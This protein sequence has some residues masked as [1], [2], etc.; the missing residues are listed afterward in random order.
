[1]TFFP[2][3]GFRVR[4]VRLSQNMTQKVFAAS[5]GIVQ[6]FLSAVENGKKMP[7]DTFLLALCGKYQIDQDWLL[8]GQGEMRGAVLGGAPAPVS[9]G[10]PLLRRITADFPAVA[11]ADIKDYVRLPGVPAGCYAVQFEGDFMAPTI[12]DGDL[13]VFQ[14]GVRAE[15][16]DIL[17]VTNHWGEVILRRYRL[18]GEQ[19]YLSADNS[20]YSPFRPDPE[21]RIVGK[22]V[23][24]WRKVKM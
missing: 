14:S 1:M 18:Q 12:S 5:L 11:D 3:V 6:G 15:N 22:V 13:V 21:T 8:T 20:S 9:G 7:S 19:I 24:I 23:A 2:A 10:I 4:E 17:L 16:R